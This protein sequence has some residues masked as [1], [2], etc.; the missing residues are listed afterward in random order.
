MNHSVPPSVCALDDNFWAGSGIA[1]MKSKSARQARGGVSLEMRMFDC[2]MSNIKFGLVA[3]RRDTY[4][5][6]VPVHKMGIMK[7]LQTL[8]RA[9][10]LLLDFSEGGGGDSEVT[11]Q[12]QSVGMI[13]VDVLHDVPAHHPL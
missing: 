3:R 4:P 7:V 10:Q 11:H 13:R 5:L 2:R 6:E 1:V 8:G 9:V 12:F